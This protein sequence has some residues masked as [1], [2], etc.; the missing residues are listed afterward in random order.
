M[1]L[2]DLV[3]QKMAASNQT[4]TSLSEIMGN[5]EERKRPKTAFALFLADQR[6]KMMKESPT[7]SLPKISGL[8]IIKWKK[9]PKEQQQIYERKLQEMN[10]LPESEA[11]QDQTSGGN[12]RY[13]VKKEHVGDNNERIDEENH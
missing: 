12:D 6:I 4:D 5:Q 3:R 2:E 11:N 7:L 10:K 9:L 13:L 1:E 8:A